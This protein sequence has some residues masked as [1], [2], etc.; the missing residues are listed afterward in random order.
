MIM[1]LAAPVDPPDEPDAMGISMDIDMLGLPVD[2]TEAGSP[3]PDAVDLPWQAT[4]VVAP[5]PSRTP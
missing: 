2:P 1:L 3:P 4:S 5:S